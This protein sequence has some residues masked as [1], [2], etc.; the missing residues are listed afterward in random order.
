MGV[1][2]PLVSQPGRRA[3]PLLAMISSGFCAGENSALGE[4]G[5]EHES[6]VRGSLQVLVICH[7]EASSR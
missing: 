5:A 6:S 3:S 1:A 7:G 4:A 2:H